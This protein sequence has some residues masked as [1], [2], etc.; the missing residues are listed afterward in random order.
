MSSGAP[1]TSKQKEGPKRLRFNS[2]DDLALLRQF[3]TE[4]PL[5][6]AEKWG[7][8]QKNVAE[9]TGKLFSIRTL[10]DHLHLILELWLQK[11]ADAQKK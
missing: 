5:E 1:S 11:D 6:D 9:I 2:D 3:V 4:N 7:N 8:I 10:K